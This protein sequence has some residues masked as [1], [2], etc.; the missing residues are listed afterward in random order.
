MRQPFGEAGEKALAGVALIVAVGQVVR[1]R[2]GVVER[3]GLDPQVVGMLASL[4][5]SAGNGSDDGHGRVSFVAEA[6]GINTVRVV[7]DLKIA[8]QQTAGQHGIARKT[9]LARARLGRRKV[10]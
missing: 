9:R 1:L 2:Q 7:Q 8:G 3:G 6:G 4:L 10:Q 5:G